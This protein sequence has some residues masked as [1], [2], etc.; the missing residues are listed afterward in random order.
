MDTPVFRVVFLRDNRV[1]SNR[2]RLVSPFI[3]TSV[4]HNKESLRLTESTRCSIHFGST[5]IPLTL[6]VRQKHY[7]GENTILLRDRFPFSYV[8]LLYNSILRLVYICTIRDL[9]VCLRSFY[10]INILHCSCTII[11]QLMILVNCYK[12]QVRVIYLI[13]LQFYTKQNNQLTCNL[14]ITYSKVRSKFQGIFQRI[15]S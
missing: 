2:L 4:S 8:V 14:R 13:I 3:V 11:Y 1:P 6:L 7:L 5:L 9:C 12:L 15:G 10:L